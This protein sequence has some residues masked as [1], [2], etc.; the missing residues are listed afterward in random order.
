M[1][2]PVGPTRN[3]TPFPTA[4]RTAPPGAWKTPCAMMT[5][6][7]PSPSRATILNCP[8]SSIT[9]KLAWLHDEL[10]MAGCVVAHLCGSGSALYGRSC[11][12]GRRRNAHCRYA[13]EKGIRA[14]IAPT[15]WIAFNRSRTTLS[16]TMLSTPTSR[17]PLYDKQNECGNGRRGPSPLRDSRRRQGE[18][19]LAGHDRAEQ[20]LA[21]NSKRQNAAAARRRR[22]IDGGR[23]RRAARPDSRCGQCAAK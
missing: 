8:S 5:M 3:W 21:G 16:I 19:G 23:G 9:R 20:S 15:P 18:T 7:A 14:R 2:P 1:F 13:A 6:T 17:N 12:S 11:R 4:N 10:R 22:G